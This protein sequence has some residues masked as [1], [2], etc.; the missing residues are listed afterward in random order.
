MFK[1]ILTQLTGTDI[2]G[3]VLSMSADIAAIHSGHIDCLYVAVDPADVVRQASQID[4]TSSTMLVEALEIIERQNKEHRSHARN[5]FSSLCRSNMIM[6]TDVPNVAN[7]VSASLKETSGNEADCLIQEGRFHDLI[8]LAG[9]AERDTRLSSQDLGEV[10]V[11]SGRPVMLAPEKNHPHSFKSI[12]I[13][14]K[15]T[16]ES[17]RAVTAAMPLLEK[18]AQIDVLTANEEGSKAVDCMNCSDSVVRQLSWHGL[19][20]RGHFVLPA[21][22]NAPDAVLESAQKAGADL[23]VMGGYGHSRLREFIFGGFTRRILKGVDLPVLLFH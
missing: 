10:I 7:G 18:A 14:W 19:K 21:G 17:A 2:D 1:T 9:G 8:V 4:L 23:L 12:A 6:H 13:A 15:D 22:R 3:S 11:A 5:S 16:A 20:A